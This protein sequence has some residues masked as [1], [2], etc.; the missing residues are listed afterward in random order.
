MTQYC[1]NC[2][3]EFA[4]DDQNC[5]NCGRPRPPVIQ[6]KYAQILNQPDPDPAHDD[7]ET[8]IT[9]PYTVLPP[10]LRE[11]APAVA[12]VASTAPASSPA[13]VVN[14][15]TPVKKDSGFNWALPTESELTGTAV[16]VAS[17]E[18]QP[19]EKAEP[20]LPSFWTCPHCVSL[21]PTSADYCENCGGIRPTATPENRVA[22][23]D[24][25]APAKPLSVPPP[26]ASPEV[27]N[28]VQQGPDTAR[29]PTEIMAALANEH[30][31]PK[32]NLNVVSS[33]LSDV[34]VSR[35]GATNEDSFFLVELNRCF[36]SKPEFFGFYMVADGM[37]GQAAGEVASRTAIQTV[38]PKIMAELAGPWLSGKNFEVAQV[39]D[40]LEEVISAAHT[41]L[42][43]YNH[44]EQIDSGTTI[45]ACCVIGN[46]AVFANVGDSRTYLF[47]PVK[48]SKGKGDITDPVLPIIPKELLE[49][50][51]GDRAT[52]KLN[53]QTDK[54]NPETVKQPEE[55]KMIVERVTRDQS[56]VQHLVE[57]GELTLDEVYDDP[58]RNVILF[59]LGAPDETVPVDTYQRTLEPGDLVLLCSD[60]LWEMVRDPAIANILL[61]QPD[62]NLAAQALV[63]QANE[64]GGADNVTVI[65]VKAV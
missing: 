10:G 52:R 38:G 8:E 16:E 41:R 59:A 36:E 51:P 9:Q 39:A 15:A 14:P 3:H 30:R 28:P 50:P 58:R 64:N 22:A 24:P 19:E 65:L 2:N 5:A 43:E 54:L 35:K 13:P 62:L 37:G 26:S 42:F 1:P 12:P 32:V 60:G 61:A 63:N 49:T 48:S 34:G 23:V 53:D 18:S 56:L 45:T 27:T 46:Q 29:I 47:R 20:E 7:E 57:Q 55:P 40:I 17:S 33:S 31:A 25:K 4:P 11:A 21:N 6:K 44:E